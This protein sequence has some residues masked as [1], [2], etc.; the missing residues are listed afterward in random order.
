M[1]H[2]DNTDKSAAQHWHPIVHCVAAQLG[3]GHTKHV[4]NMLIQL[5]AAWR[6]KS[7]ATGGFVEFTYC[8]YCHWH[9]YQD[10]VH[11]RTTNIIML[12]QYSALK[13]LY[14]MFVMSLAIY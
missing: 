11:F 6:N 12:L 5:T 8:I 10:T 7:E 9:H 4:F 1:A 14:I 13:L 2:I 3:T